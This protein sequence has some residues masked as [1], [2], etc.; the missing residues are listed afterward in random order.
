MRNIFPVIFIVLSI[1]IFF[2]V[3][4][5]MYNDAKKIKNDVEVYNTALTNATRLQK[6]RDELVS[7]YKAVT[8]AE[9]GKLDH[10]LPNTVDN[11]QLIL[12]IQNIATSHGITLKNIRFDSLSDSSSKSSES[13]SPNSG[14]VN[15]SGT[16]AAPAT[17]YGT[18][19]LSFSVDAKYENFIEF[20]KDLESNIRLVNVKNISFSVPPPGDKTAKSGPGDTPSD[21]NVYTYSLKVQT[22]WLK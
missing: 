13:P 9:K 22:Y 3:V 18:F 20:L 21:P 11:I 10:F 19:D 15:V 8:D 12:Q 7:N 14:S 16:N 1:A 6:I 5:P 4:N 2:A 17:P